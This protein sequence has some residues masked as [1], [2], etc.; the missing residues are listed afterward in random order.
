MYQK[1]LVYKIPGMD[2]VEVRRDVVYKTVEGTELKIDIYT[3]PGLPADARLP[4]IFFIH[5]GFLPQDIKLLPKDWGVY[6]SYGRLAAASGFVGVTF[7][8]RYRSWSRADLDRSF[9]DVLDAIAFVR[10]R[11][12]S[13]HADPDRAVLWG[14]SGGGPHLCLAVREKMGFVRCVVSFYGLLDL[15][16]QVRSQSLD[17]EKERTAEYS[18]ITYL[19][20]DGPPFPPIFIGRAGLDSPAIND[21]VDLFVAKALGLNL[22]LD[23]ANHPTGHHG[24]DVLDD[25]ERS[26]EIIVA[27][28]EFIKVR[29]PKG[30]SPDK[31]EGRVGSLPRHDPRGSG[32]KPASTCDPGPESDSRANALLLGR[33]PSAYRKILP[34]APYRFLTRKR[35]K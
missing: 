17:P 7:N 18:P 4:V 28:L 6:Q 24:F 31:W 20:K 29:T 10:G 23:L 19:R 26:R 9:A 15:E 3:P 12:D 8:H 1:P 16:P 35:V 30:P 22:L 27:A 25:N 2:A 5:G 11:A 32:R 21:S 33:G 14:F 13:E 34:Q